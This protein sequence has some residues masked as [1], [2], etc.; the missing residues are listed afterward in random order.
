[1]RN[2]P[3]CSELSE[4]LTDINNIK[5]TLVDDIILN[6]ALNVKLCKD[7]NFYFSES[8]NTQEDYNNYYLLFNNYQQ[9]SYCL[10]KDIKCADFICKHVNKNEIKTVIDY[11]SGNGVL[12]NLLSEKFIV[13]QFDIGME[14]NNKKYDLLILSHVLEHIYNLNSFINEVSKN[15]KDHGLFYIEVP[16]AD[17]YEEFINMCPLQEINIEHINFFSK[18]SLNKLLIDNGFYCIHLQDDYFM[19]KNMKYYVIRGVFKK[20]NNNKSFENYLNN[21]LNQIDSFKFENLKKYKNIYVYGCGQFLFKILDKIQD[22]C[23]I[24][25]IIDDNLCYAN[26]KINGV[27]IINYDM[28]K[29]ICKDGDNILLTTM[30]H[31]IK[32]KERLLLIDKNINILEIIHL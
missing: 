6:S 19:L 1:M 32:I 26:K 5:L 18:I 12:A 2:C 4:N 24:I 27:D 10:D 3:I 28:F 30:V 20:H 13:E 22:N 9:Q 8:G 15:I 29:E 23:N 14:A 17:F 21:G 25:N 31:D 7:C 16:N 11:G